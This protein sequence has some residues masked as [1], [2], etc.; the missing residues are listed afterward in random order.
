MLADETVVTTSLEL[1]R[2]TSRRMQWG[3]SL[4]QLPIPF[5]ASIHYKE[6]TD[7]GFIINR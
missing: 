5:F 1:A 6:C 3:W 7:D 2:T 4:D